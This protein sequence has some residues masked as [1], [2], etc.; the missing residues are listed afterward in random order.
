VRHLENLKL[1]DFAE[2]STHRGSERGEVFLYDIPLGNGQS[3][4][5]ANRSLGREP[6]WRFMIT[7]RDGVEWTGN[8]STAEEALL[9]VLRE[10]PVRAQ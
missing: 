10:A 4:R 9:A 1:S 2:A 5:V 8:Y 7:G 3:V 6:R